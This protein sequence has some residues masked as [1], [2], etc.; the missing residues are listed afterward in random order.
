MSSRFRYD[1]DKTTLNYDRREPIREVEIDRGGG[2][3]LGKEGDL[4]NGKRYYRK[5]EELEEIKNRRG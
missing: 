1:P 3:R 2:D 4:P 5:E